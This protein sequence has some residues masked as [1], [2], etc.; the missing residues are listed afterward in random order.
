[1][2]EAE[3]SLDVLRREHALLHEALDTIA[4]ELQRLEAEP[5]PAHRGGQL[6]GMLLMF[7]IHLGRHFELE[8]RDSLIVERAGQ[9]PGVRRALLRLLDEHRTLLSHVDGLIE[10]LELSACG[11]ASLPDAFAVSLRAFLADLGR[12]EQGETALTQELV[13]RDLGAGD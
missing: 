7:R 10:S 8:E 2:L 9:D 5:G 1:M 11:Q 13:C 6:L 3:T 4:R 12:H